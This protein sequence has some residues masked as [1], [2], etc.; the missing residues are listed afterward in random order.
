[1]KIDCVLTAVNENKFY[2]DFIPI[3]IKTWNKLYPNIDVKI[4]FIIDEIPHYLKEYES[5]IILFKPINNISTSSISQYIRILYP[6]ILHSYENG[7]IITDID[8][9]PLNK[10]YFVENIKEYTNDTF[11]SYRDIL[12][13]Q[14]QIAICYNVATSKIWSE[15][16]EINSE[17]DIHDNLI[18]NL[19]NKNDWFLDQK[20]LYKN[21]M[22]WKSK[23]NKVLFLNDKNTKF[24]RFDRSYFHLNDDVIDKISKGYYNDCHLPKPYE[25]HKDNILTLFQH[26]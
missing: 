5:N 8:M 23:N 12:L 15:I 10:T 1:M 16:F 14:R 21:V 3:F 17:K 6:S 22:K 26:L 4:I 18:K 11:I 24:R 25:N 9:I 7:I 19:K 13:G 2:H 20:E